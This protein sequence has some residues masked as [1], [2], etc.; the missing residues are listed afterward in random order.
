MLG[1]GNNLLEMFA[2]CRAGKAWKGGHLDCWAVKSGRVPDQKRLHLVGF[3]PPF[4]VELFLAFI[5][6]DLEKRLVLNFKTFGPMGPSTKTRA[7][8]GFQ[9]LRRSDQ[10]SPVKSPFCRCCQEA[11]SSLPKSAKMDS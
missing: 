9:E 4:D 3:Q 10:V 11:G 5:T 1:V 8:M 2:L 6:V 7:Q